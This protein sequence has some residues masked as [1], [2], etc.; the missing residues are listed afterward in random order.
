VDPRKARWAKIP[1]C[2]ADYRRHGVPPPEELWSLDNALS[3]RPP[4]E[5]NS[6]KPSLR[7]VILGGE[8]GPGAREHDINWDR[9]II[10]Q[11][12]ASGVPVFEKQ[13]GSRPVEGEWPICRCPECGHADSQEQFD[14]LG[15]D[16]GKVFCNS[17][18]AEIVPLD[19]YRNRKGAD[20]AEWPEDLRVREH[21]NFTAKGNRR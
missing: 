18:H 16:E 9:A 15:A 21:P 19:G 14:V 20:P 1:V 10:A 2:A 7:W 17:C 12:R 4:D 3:G 6:R 5:W 13:L 11:G 8:T